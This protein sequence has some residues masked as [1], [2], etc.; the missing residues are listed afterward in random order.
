MLYDEKPLKSDKDQRNIFIAYLFLTFGIVCIGFSAIFVKFAGVSGFVSAFYR[1]FFAGCV[2]IPWWILSKKPLPEKRVLC[3]I[4]LGG[5]FFAIDLVLWN[6]SLLFTSAATSTLL[7]NSAPIWVAFGALFVFKEKLP[8]RFWPGLTIALLGG[9]ILVGLNLWRSLTFNKG[10][11]L[12]LSAGFFYAAYLMITQKMRAKVDTLT[13]MTFAVSSG[14]IILFCTNLVSGTSFFNYPKKTWLPLIAL[15]LITHVG[16]WLSI[17]YA[18]GYLKAT[19]A[20][21]TLLAQAIVTAILAI[22]LLHEPL[23]VN[24]ITGGILILSGIYMVNQRRKPFDKN[25]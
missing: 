12:A 18:L 6:T 10:D 4:L 16:G 20:S 5:L 7:A 13:F 24:Q 9:S 14:L 23:H 3:F 22:P 19:R 8:P 15:G 1:L 17:N 21:V 25:R 2:I 11:A